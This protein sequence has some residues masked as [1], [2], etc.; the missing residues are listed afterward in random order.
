MAFRVQ[1]SAVV[2]G[3]AIGPAVRVTV[4][5]AQGNTVTSSTASITLA[6][7]SG[8]GTTSAVL[9]GTLTRAAVSGVA[10]FDDLTVDT[11]GSGY[12]LTAT[13]TGLASVTST[14]F[15]VADRSYVDDYPDS[16]AVVDAPDSFQFDSRECTSFVAWRMNRDAGTT[17]APFFFTNGMGRGWWG[18]AYNWHSNAVL[19]HFRI[20][21]TPQ[22]GAI[23]QWDSTEM[24]KSSGGHVAYVERVNADSGVD[25][26]EYNYHEDHKFDY[27]LN[28]HNV[29]RFIHVIVARSD[30]VAQN[31]VVSPA[32]GAPGSS[33]TVSFTIAN[34]GPGDANPSTSTIRLDTSSTTVKFSDPLLDSVNVPSIAAG[35]SYPVSQGVTIPA[36]TSAGS[37]YVWVVLD[38]NTVVNQTNVANDESHTAFTVTT[39]SAGSVTVTSMSPNSGPQAG[40]TSVTITGTNFAVPATA[41]IGGNALGNLTVASGTQITGTT[42]TSS[43]A[44]AKDVAVT[45]NGVTGICVGCFTYVTN[46]LGD[47]INGSIQSPGEVDEVGFAGTA[48]QEVAAFLQTLTGG[49]TNTLQLC[50][51]ADA[52]TVNE[53]SLGC[54]QSIGTDTSLWGQSTGRLVLPRTTT[55]TA[56]VGGISGGTGPYRFQVFPINRAPEIRA[57]ALV[58]NDTIDGEAIGPPG[59]IDEFSFAGTAGQEVA[60]FVQTLTGGWTNTLQACLVADAGTLNELSL[61]CAQSIGTDTS[62]WGQSTGRF[63]LPRTTTYTVRV[64]GLRSALDRGPYRMMAYLVNRAPEIRAQALVLNDTIDG[65]AIGPPGDIDEFSFAGTAGQEMAAFVQTLTGGWTNTLQA[66]LVADAG[67]LNELSLGC[68]QSIGTDTSLWGQSTGRFVLPRTTTYTVRVQGLRSALDRGPYRMMA[69][70]V[71][72]APEI[73]AQALVLNDTIDGEAIGPPGDIDEF[74]FAGTAGQEVAAF[75]QTLTGGWTN[76][77]QACLVADAGTL[78]ELSLGCAQSI[79]TDTSLWGQSTGRFVLPRTTTYT[80]RVQGLRSALD[81]GPYRMMAYLVNRAPEI[82]AQALV[83]NDTIDGEAIAPPG[84]VDEFTF[85]DT[86]GQ[87]V[88]VLFQALTGAYSNQLEL[89][90][91]ANAGTPSEQRLGLSVISN[92][93]N[94]SLEGQTTGLV[95]LP[96]TGTYVVRVMGADSRQGQ[97]AYRF[98]VR[99]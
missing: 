13:A 99:Q 43:T 18:N 41:T 54:T 96:Y 50:L 90:L 26:T 35:G 49:W 27:R 93:G 89:D 24:S 92:S 30:L 84:D 67:T 34:Q 79:G 8:T 83:L 31:L 38:A 46:A 71:N 17:V 94:T 40:G 21:H 75:V 62:L 44:G 97:G 55:Y 11:A 42:P 5:D 68:A 3:Y 22:V 77:L 47:T 60:A 1:P 98:R 85:A 9:G 58:L 65:E 45:A 86:A 69:Y 95:T 56:R 73:R 28:V 23:A 88:E 15:N 20:D 57:Q 78:N 70:L 51:V 4:Q 82:R 12:T 19:L 63:V 80:V 37:W 53:V 61:G 52:G 39:G 33:A 2:A 16:S 91:V 10:T 87:V 66:C 74:S 48:G 64:Q 6:I 7:S 72:R 36:G 81:R 14:A 29:P 59:D 32:S 25:L 76:T